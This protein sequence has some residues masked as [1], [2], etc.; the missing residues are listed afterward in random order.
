MNSC[1]DYPRTLNK[2][3]NNLIVKSEPKMVPNVS[4]TPENTQSENPITL[5]PQEFVAAAG[6]LLL[7]IIPCTKDKCP[8]NQNWQKGEADNADVLKHWENGSAA[9]IGV[10]TGKVS[11]NLIGIDFD[12]I[13]AELE[14]SWMPMLT[15]T[16][17]VT[18]GKPGHFTYF[19]RASDE[20]VEIIDGMPRKIPLGK[21]SISDSS[22]KAH[23]DI[24]WDKQQCIVYGAHPNTGLYKIRG[25]KYFHNSDIE[26]LPDGLLQRLLEESENRKNRATNKKTAQKTSKLAVKTK[27]ASK[28]KS[29]ELIN[30][31]IDREAFSKE[32]ANHLQ[33]IVAC[34]SLVSEDD[35]SNQNSWFEVT[36]GLKY[37]A[38]EHPEIEEKI[39]QIWDLWSSKSDNYDRQENFARWNSLD[40]TSDHA[41]TLGTII[42]EYCGGLNLVQQ[43]MI[44]LFPELD[45][46][47]VDSTKTGTFESCLARILE[48]QN[49]ISLDGNCY[50]WMGTHWSF[51]SD[52]KMKT[53]IARESEKFYWLKKGI[54]TYS[55]ATDKNI[56]SGFNFFKSLHN[57]SDINV[58]NTHLIAFDNGTLDVRTSILSPDHKRDD[59]LTFKVVGDYVEDAELPEVARNFFVLAFGEELIPYV[60]AVYKMYLDPTFPYG[61]FVHVIG[62]SGSGKG[63][64][65][66]LLLSMLNQTSIGSGNDLTCF[67]KPDKLMQELAGKSI[68]AL[69]DMN[70]YTRNCTGF[71]ELVD[72]G[73][74]SGRVL[75]ASH[76]ITKRWNVRF[77]IG[78]VDP[79]KVGSSNDGWARRVLQLPTK[80][81]EGKAD[82][83]LEEKLRN[84]S[85][86]IASWA[87]Q[88]KR[89]EALALIQNADANEIISESTLEAA[90]FGDPIK[91]FLDTCV[92]LTKYDTDYVPLSELYEYYKV[93]CK[94]KSYK[95]VAQNKFCAEIKSELNHLH[96]PRTTIKGKPRP[97]SLGYIRTNGCVSDDTYHLEKES[98]GNFKDLLSFKSEEAI[99][100]PDYVDVENAILEHDEDALRKICGKVRSKA[101]EEKRDQICNS[102]D[103][104]KLNKEQQ[105]LLKKAKEFLW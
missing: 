96:W 61:K 78:S 35:C 87:L 66:R 59:Y 17:G 53:Q 90:I 27:E 93:F 6:D 84:V 8:L 103:E 39:E 68:Y 7:K 81:R 55:F 97:S 3:M 33:K 25:D 46:Y 71:Y 28:S 29:S 80:R 4:I 2:E 12:G 32:D 26:Q 89:E 11:N 54:K 10:L 83:Q 99:R 82:L 38:L 86:Q 104:S 94:E 73:M 47:L 72:N 50:R 70:N 62:P 51:V 65:I 49:Y 15:P 88:M 56:I 75:Y 30:L 79:I 69:P 64:F 105:K 19:Y 77:I 45:P 43:K 24:R 92:T 13:D 95:P 63:T 34:L 44:E 67:N 74:L 91:Q 76:T 42:N 21:A 18:S 5:T 57:R 58:S 98:E 20:Q 14:E 85:A 41:I 9:S 102:I 31:E 48:S 16:I 40:D 37:E 22:K 23:I 52:D 1:S 60:R 101:S 100:D 36:A